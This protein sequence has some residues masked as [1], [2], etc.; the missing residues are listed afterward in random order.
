MTSAARNLKFKELEEKWQRRWEESRIF[1]AEIEGKEKF[2]LTVPYP[3]T[4]GPLHI[5]HG[6]TYTLG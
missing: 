4:S 3:Y 5:G 1:E 2:F 6:R